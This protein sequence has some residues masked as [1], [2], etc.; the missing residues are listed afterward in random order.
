MNNINNELERLN[1][2]IDAILKG[3]I[4]VEAA[5]DK[6]IKENIE[7]KRLKRLEAIE[8]IKEELDSKDSEEKIADISLLI[9]GG[10]ALAY[11]VG[12][13]IFK[14]NGNLINSLVVGVPMV[15]GLTS[16][17]IS[18]KIVSKLNN[19]KDLKSYSEYDSLIK[20]N[21]ELIK[22]LKEDLK[23][24]DEI[25]KELN[26]KKYYVESSINILNISNENSVKVRKL[27]K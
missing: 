20:K 10:G 17:V 21:N 16:S 18:P 27:T 9:A 22:L 19:T 2:K 25:L 12:N 3:K 6:A 8:S 26:T 7:Y 24:C 13:K 11:L 1:A 4:D 23:V 5:L 14:I 15:V